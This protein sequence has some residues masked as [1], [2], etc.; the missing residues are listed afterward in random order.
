MATGPTLDELLGEAGGARGPRLVAKS[1][2]RLGGVDPLGLRQINFGLM[3]E[4]LP[5]LNNVAQHVRPYI[6]MAW[7]WRR[8]RRIIGAS[9]KSGATDE[10]MRDFVDRMEAI[11]AW[12]Q[13]LVNRRSALPGGLALRPL[14]QA[15]KYR[16]SGAAWDEL[17]D[18]RRYSTGLISP[19]NYGPSLRTLGW[20]IPVEG[21][22]GIFQPPDGLDP[23]LDAFES[24]FASELG[25]DAFNR[26]GSVTVAAADVR[27]WGKLWNMAA[28]RKPEKKAAFERLGGALADPRR[29]A[30]VA[31]IRAAWRDLDDEGATVDAIRARMADLA[32]AWEKE[33][34]PAAAADWRA[35]QVRQAFRLALE[36]LFYWTIVTLRQNGPMR[37]VALVDTFLA[38][39]EKSLPSTSAEWMLDGANKDNPT[40]HVDALYAGLRRHA[41]LPVAVTEAIRHALREP[42]TARNFERRDRLPLGRA[43]EEA[44]MWAALSPHAFMVKLIEVWVIAQHTYWCVVRGLAD[45]RRDGKTILRMRIVMEENG[46]TLTPETSGAKPPEATPDRLETAVSLLWECDRLN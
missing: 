1:K 12:S 44:R 46:W 42:P 7:A 43:Q 41:D 25:H 30:G 45:A 5:D 15:D 39:L 31:L 8:V 38:G 35:A 22:A 19:L 9:A 16:F 24:R 37:S 27:R 36:G 4:V 18:M 23:A 17:R 29:R 20:L 32:G 3:D 2:I 34:S 14:I 26:F 13:F 10:E 21:A 40:E 28:P 6:L 33:K 11:Y